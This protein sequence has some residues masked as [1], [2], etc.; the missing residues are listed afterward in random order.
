[1]M[2]LSA[3]SGACDPALHIR[4]FEGESRWS[5]D[6]DTFGLM[7]MSLR[8]TE[9]SDAMLSIMFEYGRADVGDLPMLRQY[10][11]ELP[12]DRNAL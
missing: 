5:E 3:T 9:S 4:P 6:A 12:S 1:M 11:L 7:R 8:L 10:A 2:P